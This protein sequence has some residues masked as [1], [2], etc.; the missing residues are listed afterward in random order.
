LD[1]PKQA[2]DCIAQT[3]EL[4]LWFCLYSPT[5]AQAS[6]ELFKKLFR[7]VL[8][9]MMPDSGAKQWKLVNS[10]VKEMILAKALNETEILKLFQDFVEPLTSEF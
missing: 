8:L 1:S 3:L 10:I 9:P 5:T 4:L 2:Q 7:E 6:T